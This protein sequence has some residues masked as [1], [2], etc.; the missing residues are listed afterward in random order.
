VLSRQEKKRRRKRL[1]KGSWEVKAFFCS[2]VKASFR[3]TLRKKLLQ[4][5]QN[6]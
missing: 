2:G 4:V 5:T 3:Q 1:K 6:F